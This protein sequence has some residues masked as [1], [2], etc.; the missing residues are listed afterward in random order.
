MHLCDRYSAAPRILQQLRTHLPVSNAQDRAARQFILP[1]AVN[2]VD[3]N[4]TGGYN[5]QWNLNV[6]RD[7]WAH[8]V[9]TVGYVGSKGTRLYAGE[10]LNPAVYIPGGSSTTNV[11]SRRIYQGFTTI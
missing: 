2:S 8:I 3:P 1:L 9:L 4:F 6:Q 5:Q 11:D 7:V 10:N